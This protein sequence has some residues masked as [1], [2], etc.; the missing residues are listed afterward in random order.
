MQSNPVRSRAVLALIVLVVATAIPADAARVRRLEL[1][2]VR[3]SAESVFAGEVVGVS[4][5]L[6][7][8][9]Q[10][11]WTDYE[12]EVSETLAGRNPGPRT[13]VSFAGG[14]LPELSI[15]VPGVPKLREGD[16]YVFFIEPKLDSPTALMAMPT[17][18]WGQG[19]YR[20]ARI[21]AAGG[22]RT[23]LVSTDGE[24]LE[25][26]SDGRLS[27]GALVRIVDGRVVEPETA[28]RDG[29]GTRVRPSFFES[30][31]GTVRPITVS[32]APAEVAVRTA[33]TFAT[34]DDLR[35]FAQGRLAAV[36]IRNR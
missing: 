11:V 24:P 10:M 28:I 26:S 17:I 19:L 31:D 5:R 3:A 27:R 35:L 30:P 18:G 13:T 8:N 2:E 33:R 29:A 25:I 23:V 9:G 32:P 4:L 21:D 14:T 16:H 22:P 7:S 34:L 20:I 36:T 1:A 12:I 15:G 6:G